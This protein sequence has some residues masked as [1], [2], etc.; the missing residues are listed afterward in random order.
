MSMNRN[1]VKYLP[2]ILTVL[3]ASAVLLLSFF[4]H[5]G[6]PIS[7]EAAK[8]LGI[9]LVA[10]G[11]ALVVWAATHIR[12]AFLGE[13]Q[14]RLAELIQTGPYQFV[15]H[16]VYLGMTIALAGVAISLRS[17]P[18]LIAVFLLFLPSQVYRARLE[19]KALL[20]EFGARWKDYARRT[21]FILPQ[22][23]RD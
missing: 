5:P 19:E 1:T 23:R 14:P 13:V 8:T 16:P 11:M 21:G 12:D 17:W 6:F 2:A 4:V 18:G 22:R 20:Q 10:G 9:L 7:R 15:R 3:A